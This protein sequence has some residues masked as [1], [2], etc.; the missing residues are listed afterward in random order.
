[1]N[2]LTKV[3]FTGVLATASF[4]GTSVSAAT[5]VS[6]ATFPGNGDRETI[7]GMTDETGI[8]PL[9]MSRGGG[10]Q[11][12]GGGNSFNSNGWATNV[13]G[14]PTVLNSNGYVEI[15]FT[16][17]DGF[18]VT[19]DE[20]L[21]GSDS[22][23]SGPSQIGIFT[24]LDNFT[25]PFSTIDEDGEFSN[26]RLDISALGPVTGDFAIR[27]FNTGGVNPAAPE[28]GEFDMD[29]D[30]TW[31]IVTLFEGGFVADTPGITGTVSAIPEPSAA[32]LLALS[33]LS[34]L[35]RRRRK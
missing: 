6:Y 35:R 9:A 25:T 24:S 22:S 21:L 33:F 2:L 1:M 15:G 5:I 29:E 11:P 8:T 28:A 18:T 13:D 26:T 17:A 12:A 3:F 16:V 30:S 7:P 14:D 4:V 31:R 27:F 20:L 23:T 34:V 19:L 10:L 32:S